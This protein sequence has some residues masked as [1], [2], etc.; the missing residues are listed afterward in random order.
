MPFVVLE[1]LALQLVALGGLVLE[2]DL[3][4]LVQ[5]ARDLET[6]AD[7]APA[8]NCGLRKNRRIGPEEDRRARAARGTEL[9]HAADRSPLLVLLFP[10][11]AVAADR[12]DELAR[13]RVHDRGADAVESAGRLVVLPFE[14]AAGVERREN[15]FERARLRL[16]MLVDRDPAAVVLNRD[17]RRRPCGARRR[18]ST[19]GRSSPRQRR[20]RGSPRRDGAARASPTP[21][22][23]MPG[24]R[25][26]GSSPSR[27]V[28][29]FAV[30]VATA[31][32]G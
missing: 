18:C 24:R 21:P 27:T 19:R 9:L 6:L 16:R 4:A 8:S 32:T 7:D 10:G 28:M 12:R 22:M 31:V 17:R 11:G 30:Y 25:R 2:R 15:H 1:R 5:V 14:L 3:E 26:T 29:S 20:C 23:Y 13:Q